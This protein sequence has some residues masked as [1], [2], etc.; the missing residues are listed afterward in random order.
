[1]G[2]KGVVYIRVKSAWSTNYYIDASINRKKF[3]GLAEG[4]TELVR[5]HP[6]ALQNFIFED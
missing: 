1:M 3:I 2:Y 4:T 5:L 6:K